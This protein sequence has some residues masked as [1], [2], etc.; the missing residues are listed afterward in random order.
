MQETSLNGKS[1]DMVAENI[2]KLKEIFPEVVTEDKIDFTMLRALLGEHIDDANERYSFTW[3]GKVAALRLSQTP[4]TGTL[5]PCQQ[6]SKDW[7]ITQNL[8]LEG[9][10]LEVLKLLQKSYH[11]KVKAIYID[12]PYNTGKDFVYA[13]DYRDTLE[14]YLRLTG[15]RNRDG[16]RETAHSEMAGRYHTNW[17]NMM[18]PRLRLA[19]NLLTDDGVIFISIDDNEL[20]NL[21]KLCNEVFGENNFIDIFSW[22]KTET[23]ANLSKKTKK[24]VEYILCY[25]KSKNDHKFKGLAKKSKSSNGLLNQTNARKRLVFP[26][27]VVDTSLADGVYPAGKYGTNSYDITL[28]E[29]TEVKDGYFIRDVVLEGNFK[30]SQAKLNKEIEAGTKISIK[31]I[32]FSPSYERKEYEPEVPWNLINRSFNVKTNEEASKELERLFGCKVFDYPKPVSLIKY[33]LNFIVGNNDLVLDFFSGSATTAQ[34]VMELNAEDDGQRKFIL[35][36]LPEA[37]SP[38]SE[39]ARAGY[40]NICEIGKE[41]IRRAG[42]KIKEEQG[43]AVGLDT[44]FKVF[45]LA[46]SNLKK[47]QPDGENS[48]EDMMTH[49]VEGRSEL[50]VVYEIILKYGMEL[51][52]PVEEYE[53]TGK[54]LYCVGK[55]A[56]VICLADDISTDLAPGLIELKAK[57]NPEKMRVVFKDNGF[58][59]DAMKTKMKE[60]LKQAQI[61]DFVTV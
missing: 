48:L 60:L 29:D 33:L 54:K 8:Y 32:A 10:N 50:D 40:H 5:L 31:T 4:S 39:A 46:S 61:E 21:K 58:S 43:V 9:D 22:V 17:L 26:R 53:L 45:K 41:R 24:A 18:Y 30:W 1:M 37:C 25:Q 56:L 49:Y 19:R 15:Q 6:E 16:S 13:D 28:V 2:K 14:N 3:H 59:S 27:H 57:L 52:L 38:T 55:G 51:T 11:N 23:P 20:D 34:A 47:W 7:A 44:G 35:V 36:Q 12:P 42:E